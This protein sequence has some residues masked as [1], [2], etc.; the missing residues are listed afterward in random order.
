MPRP[1]PT[2]I[3]R[4]CAC[5]LACAVLA[6]ACGG[7][8][9]ERVLVVVNVESPV[10]VAIGEWYA[11]RRGI[12]ARNVARIAVGVADPALRTDAHETIDRER[13][14][15]LVRDPIAAHLDRSGLRDAIEV[16]VTTKGVPLRIDAERVALDVRLRDSLQASVDAE[17][18]LLGTTLD[19]APGVA[20]TPNPY[21]RSRE[22][23]RDFRARR[24][25]D[26]LPRYLVARLTGPIAA[27]D[28]PGAV[29]ASV[30]ALVEAAE[31][32]PEPDAARAWVL[33][34]NARLRGGMGVANARL[35]G[36][37]AAA[38]GAARVPVQ[39]DDGPDE[40]RDAPA[41]A[42]Y[43]SWGSNDPDHPPRPYYGAFGGHVH[44][45]RFAPR[46]VAVDFVSTGAR[47]FTAGATYGQ[48]LA[49]DLLAL[50]VAGV[51]GHVAEPMLAAVPRPDVL[52]GRYAEGVPAVEA[53]WS[54]VPFLGWM[55]TW[56]GDPMLRLEAPPARPGRPR[57]RDGDGVPDDR[58]VC[59]D[60]P[61]PDQRDS[62]RDGY[63][64]ACDA[65]VDGDGVVTTSWGA[66]FPLD[67]RGD[68]EWIALTAKAGA[69]DADHDLDGDGRVDET[70]VAI[71]Q[72]AVF[73]PPGPS[74][75]DGRD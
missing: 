67:E 39:R 69:Y 10:S 6:A 21:F 48:S 7:D 18:M 50:G 16:I 17:L 5:V 58:D 56:V 8:A 41:I 44:P 55:H 57:D 31:A 9:P 4:A 40:V 25:A 38:L 3:A 12:P 30:R 28:A 49:M 47:T 42:A 59:T 13:W 53:Y 72:L 65:D 11:Q 74:A 36:A 14:R 62:D 1:L 19:E 64:N 73:Q 37:A 26:A 63:G 32:R 23:F 68:V 45:G 22:R 75:A 54:S 29:P 51:G 46:A 61:D 2:P 35:L 52:F 66:V 43:A 71:A 60:V 33:D 70:D 15:T 20:R 27:S 34:G 24:G